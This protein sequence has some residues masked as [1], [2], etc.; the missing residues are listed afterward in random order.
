MGAMTNKIIQIHLIKNRYFQSVSIIFFRVQ[1][2][3]FL[4]KKIKSLYK[5]FLYVYKTEIL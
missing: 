2:L 1:I 4:D 5:Q 3:Y